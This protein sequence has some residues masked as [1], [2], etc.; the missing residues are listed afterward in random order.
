MEACGVRSRTNFVPRRQGDRGSAFEDAL[1]LLAAMV[2]IPTE[3]RKPNAAL[4]DLV[5]ERAEAAGAD[6]KRVEGPAGR[7]NLHVRFGPEAPGGVL[8]SGHTDVVPAG[9]GW[10]SDPYQL[11]V[12]G[13]RLLGRGTADMK[14]FIACALAVACRS[15]ISGWT[16]PLHLCLS[17]DEEIG[18]VGVASLLSRLAVDPLVAPRVVLVGEPTELTLCTSHSGKVT[19]TL[20]A[21]C[22]PG[23]SSL[24]PTR[25]NAL[26]QVV[27][28]AR[29][30]IEVGSRAAEVG[31]STNVGTLWGGTAVNVLAAAA[32]VSFECR[33]QYCSDPQ[34]MLSGVWSQVEKARSAM[35]KLEGGLEV[36]C[37]TRY[38]ALFTR[39]DDPEVRF[40]ADLTGRSCAGHLPFGCEAGLYAEALAVPAVVFG[41]GSISNAHRPDEFVTRKQ[42]VETCSTLRVVLDG[43]CRSGCPPRQAPDPNR[44]HASADPIPNMRFKT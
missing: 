8:V 17:Y 9:S 6:L 2:A 16:A 14:G 33:H 35:S 1:D 15:D 25:T 3:S 22:D 12:D 11:A 28:V 42:L 36:V 27:A 39:E 37:D 30:V 13:E 44:R 43:Y 38:P 34:E 4:V 10:T 19:Y 21:S 7:A 18:C 41:P 23:H 24:A 40:L 29:A 26:D 32:E 31:G 5:S 20:R